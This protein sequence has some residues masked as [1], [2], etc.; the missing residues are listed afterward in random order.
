[1]QDHDRRSDDIRDEAA[2]EAPASPAD[3]RLYDLPG[4]QG[5]ISKQRD[6]QHPAGPY[7]GDKYSAATDDDHILMAL[8]QFGRTG[9]A[10][11]GMSRIR[12]R[13][14]LWRVRR[15]LLSFHIRE[16]FALIASVEPMLT[17]LPPEESGPFRHD[18][19]LLR[20]MGF[21][22]QDNSLAALAT[23]SAMPG[24]NP[25]CSNDPMAAALCQLAHWQLGNYGSMQTV[26]RR[27]RN[28]ALAEHGI[29]ADILSLIV[30]A[31]MQLQQMR[32]PA[33]RRA[34]MD[35]LGMT[36]RLARPEPVLAALATAAAAP[37]LYEQGL[38]EE[39]EALV[40]RQLEKVKTS[41]TL[42]CVWQV[43]LVLSRIAAHGKRYDFALLLL[44]QAE[45]LGLARG[46]SRL[47]ALSLA[48][49]VHLLLR[50]GEIDQAGLCLGR[51]DRYAAAFEP[52]MG[53]PAIAIHRYRD[54][55]RARMA[56]AGRPSPT[57]LA[58][59]RRLHG[60]AI[61]R[62]DLYSAMRIGLQIAAALD[63]L[64]AIE[65]A[66]AL[67]LKALRLGTITGLFQV[68][69]DEGAVVGRIVL[70]VYQAALK[71]DSR[72]KDILAYAGSLLEH[73]NRGSAEPA[74]SGPRPRE[75]DCLSA[76][77]RDILNLIGR[78]LSNKRIAQSLKIAPETV[79][80]HV[81]RIFS[82]LAAKT[83]AEA[84]ARADALGLL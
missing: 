28:S 20:A 14:N 55:A 78:G 80:S 22:L 18:I 62:L 56:L 52:H 13:R 76:R 50:A 27:D 48:E 70:R 29:P 25:A 35:A 10:T 33:A 7:P 9:G 68:F 26:P 38:L 47:V 84:V 83:R 59:L 60:E 69:L 30:D 2:G 79:K 31:A 40:L 63:L 67:I 5:R 6:R 74:A 23:A 16:G 41:G 64:G 61:H 65:E 17:D 72:I 46:W 3:E 58:D 39:A 81:K 44:R 77:E 37:A 73:G 71:P 34:A 19:G 12:I 43:H 8:L 36:D 42:D 49:R 24:A 66:D 51:L 11:E 75:R 15:R 4:G 54:I 45:N 21:A 32:L 82:K 53:H 1:M 57:V